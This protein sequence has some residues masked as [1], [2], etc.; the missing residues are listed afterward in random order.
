M[1]NWLVI[2]GINMIMFISP[3]RLLK[4]SHFPL[5]SRMSPHHGDRIV[6]AAYG[7]VLI[8]LGSNSS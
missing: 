3:Q 2:F 8:A 6:V 4:L 5:I 7:V 1:K